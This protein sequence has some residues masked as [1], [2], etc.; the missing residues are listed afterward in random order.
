YRILN[1]SAVKWEE[2]HYQ[3]IGYGDDDAVVTSVTDQ[4]RDWVVLPKG[5]ALL[6]VRASDHPKVKEW[7]LK[8]LNCREASKF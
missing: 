7:K 2:V 4:N 5:D 3:I 8:I 1:D 6:T